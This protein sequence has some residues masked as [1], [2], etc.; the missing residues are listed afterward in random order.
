MIYAQAAQQL[1]T[2]TGRRRDRKRVARDVYIERAGSASECI[3]LRA[4]RD[5]L[6]FWH[7]D[8]SVELRGNS[9]RTQSLYNR[10]LP[11]Q[12]YVLGTRPYWMLRTPRGTFPF[13]SRMRVDSHG[14]VP[15]LPNPLAGGYA[16]EIT[17]NIREYATGYARALVR[18]DVGRQDTCDGCAIDSEIEQVRLSHIWDHVRAHAFVPQIIQAVL[19]TRRTFG[20][21]FLHTLARACSPEYR[22]MRQKPRNKA[23]AIERAELL[24]GATEDPLL[25]IQ[26][27]RHLRLLREA[28][29]R[30]LLETF[31][32]ELIR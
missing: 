31:Y 9:W 19:P 28:V 10:Y 29:E 4:G 8:G 18:G 32:F 7:P 2:P 13:Y 17:R 27:K 16:I 5:W 6:F 3:G 25:H 12:M 23:Q 21:Q 15:A 24:L 22:K 26:P 1:V 20:D 11:S 30:W 14:N